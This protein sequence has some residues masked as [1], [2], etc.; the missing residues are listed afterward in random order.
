MNQ[1]RDTKF[2]DSHRISGEH[3]IGYHQDH[4]GREEGRTVLPATHRFAVLTCMDARIDAAR[5]AGSRGSDAHIIRNAGARATEDAIRSLVLS[6]KLLG[7]R[8]WFIVQ[9]SHCGMALLNEELTRELLNSGPRGN[10]S[11][12]MKISV[13][14]AGEG[15]HVH[16]LALRDQE[17]SVAADVARVRNHPLVP[18]DVPIYGYI[19][20][21][22]TGRFIEVA[23]SLESAA[24]P[25]REVTTLPRAAAR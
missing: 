2:A 21:V 22:D 5:L 24:R 9:H 4:F 7:T 19:Y 12:A 6:Y 13:P 1:N 10:A 18:A 23:A 25:V 14:T 20:D 11:T 8:E 16:K 3:V 15:G 17:Q